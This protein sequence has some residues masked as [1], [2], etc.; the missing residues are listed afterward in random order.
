MPRRGYIF[1]EDRI[2][3]ITE[4]FNYDKLNVHPND[5]GR[6]C[7]YESR[8]DS[9]KI[10]VYLRT[11]T[12]ATCLE[13]PRSGKTQLFRRNN[14]LSDIK[15]IF[16]NPRIHTGRGYYTSFQIGGHIDSHSVA[17]KR[18]YSH[19]SEKLRSLRS[20]L[21]EKTV[22]SISMGVDSFFILY[23]DG[24]FDYGD[25]PI[26]RKIQFQKL[27]LLDLITRIPTSYNL[28]MELNHTG[29]FQKI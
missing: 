17:A 15:D 3:S 6:M 24:T 16:E 4:E 19:C 27:F 5:R 13:H 22:H 18:L 12:V 2:D 21:N 14:T 29:T 20:E 1:S 9:V 11:G 7:S 10:H 23:G 28:Q 8:E 25:I 26:L